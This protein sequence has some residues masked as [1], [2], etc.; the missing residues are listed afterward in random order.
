MKKAKKDATINLRL[1]YE[2]KELLTTLAENHGKSSS[3][4]LRLLIEKDANAVISN[5]NTQQHI[6]HKQMVINSLKENQF[7]NSLL[8]NTEISN[9]GKKAIGRELRKYV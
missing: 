3:A 7:I 4:Y 5:Q 2:T 8:A 1:P 9:K 6:S